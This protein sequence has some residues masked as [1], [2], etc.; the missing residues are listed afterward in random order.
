MDSNKS[1]NDDLFGANHVLGSNPLVKLLGGK[2]TKLKSRLLEGDSLLVG[3]LGNLGGSV[4]T[5][6][7]VKG[8]DKH[9]GLLHELLNSLL[10][11]N[12]T[13]NTVDAERLGTISN[14]AD[15]RKQVGNHNRLENVKLKLARGTSK[16]DGG[17][18]TE[19]LG[20]EHGQGLVLSG[21]N[22]TG[23]D[24]RTGLV[25]GEV[26]LAVS[27]SGT[28]AKVS[29]V[30]GNLEKRDS[31]SV[32][33]TRGLNNGIVG[34]KSLE[35]VGGGVE[36]LASDLSDSVSNGLVETNSG[37][38][39][40]TDSGTT[41]SKESQARKSVLNTLNAVGN[42]SSVT[43]ELLA[44]GQGSG[45]L[46]VGSTNLD[47][48]AELLGLVINSLV[49]SLKGG[50]QLVGDLENSRN[51]HDSGESVVRRLGHVDVVVGVNRLLGTKLAAKQLNCTVG[52]DLVRVHVR[53]GTGT[54]L[55]NNKGEV[56]SELALEDLSGSGL[57]SLTNLGVKTVGHV[58]GGSG[59]L[60]DTKS[61][62]QGLGETL[63]GTTNVKV[64]EG[65]LGLS[66]PV[67]GVVDLNLTKGIGLD[68]LA[69]SK[70]RDRKLSSSSKAHR[71]RRGG[72]SS[73]HC[74]I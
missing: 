13:L 32:K 59:L 35:L 56:V 46:Q 61:L 27:T 22:L 14:Q 1:A 31:N 42:L 2:D 29:N 57:D 37:V 74:E 20:T 48:G 3:V 10:V 6:L 51:V 34:S 67:L 63:T 9:E 62:D 7:G 58:D 40:S 26:E 72:D 8:G 12:N 71:L 60:Q 4:V 69:K 68:S 55:E 33:G 53:L 65:T 19:N 38:K 43:R 47:D 25:L 24:R 73:Q 70:S 45:I 36:L 66:T 23:H 21:V 15:R 5:N 16:S 54:G 39:T 28:G 49:E 50:D 44:E 52:N 64:L 30:V 17:V 11:G 18:V 41:L